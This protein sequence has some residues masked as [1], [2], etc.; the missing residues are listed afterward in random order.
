MSHASKV[1]RRLSEAVAPEVIEHVY[2]PR[3]AAEMVVVFPLLSAANAAHL[4]ML[5]RQGILSRAHARA[6]AGALLRMDE[7]G[8]GA[9]DP[10]PRLEDAYFNVEARLVALC[11]ADAGGRL[12]IARSRNDLSAALDRMRAREA[13]L[14][15]AAGALEVRRTLL[16]RGTLFAEVVMPGHTH[17]QPA[18]PITFGY[19][20]TGL[21]SALARDTARLL[22][23]WP[24]LNLSPM[25]AAAM[26]TTT[27]P[28][29]RPLVARL[30]GFDGVLEHGLDCVASRDFSVELVAAAAQLALTL[31]RFA[32]DMHV[33]VSHE[34][35]AVEFPDSVCGTSS[36]MPQKKNPVVL[37]HLKAK[38]AHVVAAFASAGACIRASHFTNTLDAHRE[39]QAMVWPAAVPRRASRSRRRCARAPARAPPR[40]AP[41]RPS[42]APR[43]G[44]RACW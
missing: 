11:G 13:L 26:A 34:F 10:D 36:I 41:A 31:S 43:D 3:L 35:S 21:A 8:A 17:L 40:P 29:D 38:A 24:R 27:F 15:L 39:G 32:Q 42:P 6:I 7:E 23:A 22:D 37:E 28:I 1:S 19:Y 30:L 16:E 20:L 25:G 4:V 9:I 2:A 12:H 5:E 18:Q 33:A 14:R 44:R